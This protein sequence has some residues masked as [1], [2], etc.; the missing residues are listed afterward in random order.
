MMEESKRS[1]PVPILVAICVLVGGGAYFAMNYKVK[2]L[3]Q[4]AIHAKSVETT[5]SDPLDDLIFVSTVRDPD[6]GDPLGAAQVQ[7]PDPFAR[8][9]KVGRAATKY[10]HLRIGSWALSGFGPSKLASEH[11]RMNLVRMVRKFDIIALQQVTATERDLLP[12]AVD[13]INEGGGAFDYVLGEPTGPA[14]RPEQ[15]AILF[16]S[17]RVH[18][19]RS[20]TY[21]VADPHNQMSYDPMVA[22]FRAA[23]PAT[24][25][26]WTFSIVNVRISLARAP[27]EVALL[28]SVFSAVRSDG[29]G[30][31]DVLMMG[32]FQADDQYLVPRVMGGNI[33]AAVNSSTTDIFNRHQTCNILVDRHRTGEYVGRG[34]PVDFVRMFNMNLAEAEAISSHLPI[35]A[36][37]TATE[38]GKL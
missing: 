12:R 30:E 15:L 21:T 3:D 25:E 32:L 20:Q 23:E 27:V 37:F 11:S 7:T 8:A 28:P 38:G 13:M 4:L 5:T 34:G 31:D 6:G 10:S 22:W 1:S 33:V 17:K 35:F 14:D 26:S 2:G 19:D 36:E 24:T 9:G 29:R 16:N 18:I